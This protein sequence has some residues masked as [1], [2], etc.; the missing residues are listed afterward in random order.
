MEV[1]LEHVAKLLPNFSRLYP[2]VRADFIKSFLSTNTHGSR[3]GF[4]CVPERVQNINC[5]EF[6]NGFLYF[7]THLIHVCIRL[8][9]ILVDQC[10]IAN[11]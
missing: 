7:I 8:N 1:F 5:C 3:A 10:V 2:F 11:F 6:L 4:K 9:K